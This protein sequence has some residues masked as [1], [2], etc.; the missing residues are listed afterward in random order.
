MEILSSN[1]V[2]LLYENDV[3]YQINNE[4]TKKLRADLH[5]QKLYSSRLNEANGFDVSRI[6]GWD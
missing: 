3:I 4:N 1:V 6:S 5:G 2:H